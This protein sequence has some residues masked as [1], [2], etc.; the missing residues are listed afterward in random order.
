[1][2]KT[3]KMGPITVIL[4]KKEDYWNM[5]MN[6]AWKGK[7]KKKGKKQKSIKP[8]AGKKTNTTKAP[9]KKSYT[10]KGYTT[11]D[12]TTSGIYGNYG[13]YATYG[14]KKTCHDEPTEVVTNLFLASGTGAEEYIKNPQNNIGLAVPL[15]RMDDEV[16]DKGWRGDVLYVP[17]QDYGTLPKDLAITTALKVLE[18]MKTQKVIMFCMG[19]H[20]R[21]GYIASIVLGYMGYEDPVEFIRNKYCKSAVESQSQLNQIAEILDNE[22]IKEHTIKSS[23]ISTYWDNIRDTTTTKA[24]TRHTHKLQCYTCKYWMDGIYNAAGEGWCEVYRMMMTP[25]TAEYCS[26]YADIDELPET[27]LAEEREKTL[28]NPEDSICL[29]CIFI[30]ESAGSGFFECKSAYSGRLEVTAWEKACKRFVFGGEI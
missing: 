22:K 14:G 16:W 8:Q 15:N 1:M 7:K 4:K 13:T 21:T 28:D 24:T 25:D 29:D 30:G 5:N 26:V 2:E 10:S 27:T 6:V 11:K 17:C 23:Y 20:G 3:L 18:A 9:N 19:G 12:Y